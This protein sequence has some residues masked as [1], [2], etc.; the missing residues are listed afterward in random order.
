MGSAV[1]T[2]AGSLPARY[3][4][5]AASAVNLVT[6][7]GTNAFR[8]NVFE[9]I[10][11]YHFNARNFFAPARDS[12]KR[13]QFGGTLGGPVIKDKLFFFDGYQG[14]VEKSNPPTSTSFV[15]TAAML[16][17]D[18]TA[19]ASPSCSG[20]RP[21]ERRK[22]TGACRNPAPS[23]VVPMKRREGADETG[24]GQCG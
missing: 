5:H 11:D 21:A 3:G 4:H 24:D 17:G 22:S 15:P 10:R 12:L 18:F 14:R 1:E 8:G 9:F 13:H 6:K 23:F 16:A 19:I 20:R 2:T 7:S